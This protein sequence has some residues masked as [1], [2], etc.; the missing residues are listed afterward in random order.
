VL[1]LTRSDKPG[2]GFSP[3]EAAELLAWPGLWRMGL[4]HWRAGLAEL[5][6]SASRRAFADSLRGLVPEIGVEDLRPAPAGVRAQAMGRDGKLLDDF[7]LVE[8]EGMVHVL[9]APSPAATAALA[10]GRWIA[11]RAREHL[12]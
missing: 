6:R 2:S 12:G 4:R 8:G 11:E 9:N 10:I 3:R 1:A 7:H 5:H